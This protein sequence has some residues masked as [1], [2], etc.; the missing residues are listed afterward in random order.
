[1]NRNGTSGSV[2]QR[3][4]NLV[5]QRLNQSTHPTRADTEEKGPY[6]TL[7]QIAEQYQIS[8]RNLSEARKQV[9]AGNSRRTYNFCIAPIIY[10]QHPLDI[11]GRATPQ[12]HNL[13]Y[14]Q[15]SLD[16]KFIS[17]KVQISISL[18]SIRTATLKASS[19]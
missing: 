11:K 18:I 17:P 2:H 19:E 7:N 14:G 10:K 16:D 13:R 9:S 3:L 1:M 15:S 12:Q 6:D 5:D 4:D 8:P